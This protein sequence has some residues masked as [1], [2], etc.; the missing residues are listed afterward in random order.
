[1]HSQDHINDNTAQT[2]EV[3]YPDQEKIAFYRRVHSEQRSP[4][5]MIGEMAALR[6]LLITHGPALPGEVAQGAVLHLFDL[7]MRVAAH[8]A[9]DEE[10][11]MAKYHAFRVP[12]QHRN[13]VGNRNAMIA[14]AVA[15]DA[16]RVAPHLLGDSQ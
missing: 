4:V 10:A 3:P 6:A 9:P 11:V 13:G 1:M 5:E 8:A 16:R 14:V 15:A 2:A 12:L 7:Q